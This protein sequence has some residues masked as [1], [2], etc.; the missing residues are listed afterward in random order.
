[1]D[2]SEIEPHYGHRLMPL[3][4]DE[5]AVSKPANVYASIIHG[6][7]VSAGFDDITWSRF[8][9]AVNRMAWWL[10]STLGDR[11]PHSP[12]VGYLGPAD[13]R[14]FILVLAANKAGFK[15]RCL[16]TCSNER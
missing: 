2:T 10:E 12:T 3:L 8:A 15:V 13:I 14:Y 7:D 11:G 5:L 6:N 1:M 4:V 16:R 9:N